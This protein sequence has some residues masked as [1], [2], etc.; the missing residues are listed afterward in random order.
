MEKNKKLE[1]EIKKLRKKKKRE[2]WVLFYGIWIMIILFILGLILRVI[3]GIKS[4]FYQNPYSKV[5]EVAGIRELGT[6]YIK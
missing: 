1:K 5:V 4:G 3:V 6:C 2:N